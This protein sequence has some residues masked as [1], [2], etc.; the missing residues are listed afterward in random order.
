MNTSKFKNL[1]ISAIIASAVASGALYLNQEQTVQ[2]SP[3][4][5]VQVQDNSILK[6]INSNNPDSVKK[7]IWD[8]HFNSLGSMENLDR[9]SIMI[10]LNAHKEFLKTW[11]QSIYES[12]GAH[13]NTFISRYEVRLKRVVQL[14]EEGKT[15]P[16]FQEFKDN[17]TTYLNDR[18]NITMSK[19]NEGTDIVALYNGFYENIPKE[20]I[21]TG[22]SADEKIKDDGKSV[23]NI[24]TK[25]DKTKIE[26]KLKAYKIAIEKNLI[27]EVPTEELMS[28]LLS[29]GRSDFGHNSLDNNNQESMAVYKKLRKQGFGDLESGFVA[30]LH[31]KRMVSENLGITF[32]QAWCGSQRTHYIERYEANL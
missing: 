31:E 21:I 8:D 23:E 6:T 29:E 15:N 9:E 22:Y 19:S 14:L 7:K 1:A 10:R 16:N 18:Y 26:P 28:L 12:H 2:V 25:F 24:A 27:K 11:V 32:Y 5:T 17:V 30:T 20:N 3:I 4:K 13:V